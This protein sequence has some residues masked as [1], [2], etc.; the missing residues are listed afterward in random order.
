MENEKLKILTSSYVGPLA[1][2]EDSADKFISGI[3]YCSLLEKLAEQQ[4]A[5][6]LILE[7]SADAKQRKEAMETNADLELV[8]L[9]LGET[10]GLEC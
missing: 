9:T 6:N 4:E 8:W 3:V 7:S 1:K 2:A 5:V 10:L